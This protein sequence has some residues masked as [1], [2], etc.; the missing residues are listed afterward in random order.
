[1]SS[2][3]EIKPPPGVRKFHSKQSQ[4]GEHLPS[5]AFRIVLLGP[6]SSGKT[7]AMQSMILNHYRGVFQKMF[8]WSPTSRLDS[9]WEPVFRFMQRELGQDPEATG[10][11]QCVWDTFSGA[12][13]EAVVEK[14]TKI[15]KELKSRRSDKSIELPNILLMCDDFADQVD[16]MRRSGF[17][18]AF[19]RLRHQQISC[20][21]LSQRWRLLDPTVRVN[22]TGILVWRLRDVD[23]LDQCIRSLGAKYGRDITMEI[24]KRCTK[25]KYSFMYFN[26]LTNTF[27][28]RFEHE[29][30]VPG[31]D[32]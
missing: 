26:A 6:G 32:D 22:L 5:T 28:C 25:E 1:M 9:G 21:V 23:E 19:L 2:R 15:V 14:H 24:Y 27:Y 20:A 30:R 3:L 17:V 8:L 11:E 12:D 10:E 7:L 16:V 31:V 13:L 4:L 18:T 29:V